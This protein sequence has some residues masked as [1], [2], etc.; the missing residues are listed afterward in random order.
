MFM[1]L[2]TSGC[3]VDGLEAT[4][5]HLILYMVACILLLIIVCRIGV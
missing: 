2:H 3:V 4:A 5:A 1:L